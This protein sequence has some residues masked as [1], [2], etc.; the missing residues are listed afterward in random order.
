MPTLAVIRRCTLPYG[1]WTCADGREV[2]FN[3]HYQPIWQRHH[4][5][6]TPARS[7]WV[8]WVDPF[9][10]YLDSDIRHTRR[11]HARLTRILDDFQ[12][13]LTIRPMK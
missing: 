6:V 11:L 5:V 10:F 3:R 9:H 8:D 12:H 2:L 1:C 4:G 13:G 7:Q